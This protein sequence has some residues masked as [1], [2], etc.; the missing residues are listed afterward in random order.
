MGSKLAGGRTGAAGRG[1]RR[2]E[3]LR[4]AR[5]RPDGGARAEAEGGAAAAGLTA[6][7]GAAAM[8]AETRDVAGG[9]GGGPG[10]RCG[11]GGRTA[12]QAKSGGGGRPSSGGG[13]A[14]DATE[15][16]VELGVENSDPGDSAE[17]E[18]GVSTGGGVAGGVMKT[19]RFP[20]LPITGGGVD[21]ISATSSRWPTPLA[22][23]RTSARASSLLA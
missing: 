15:R 19:V 10:G 21:A 13:D 17:R 8:A 14:G 22:R 16:G 4:A 2:P 6:E 18:V 1:G 12:A 3:E 9:G 7:H 20:A 23:T 5:W 11:G